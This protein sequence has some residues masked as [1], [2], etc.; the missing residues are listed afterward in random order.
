MKKD[1]TFQMR[2]S[3]ELEAIMKREAEIAGLNLSAYVEYCIR[4]TAREDQ[5]LRNM[6]SGLKEI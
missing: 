1:K 2:I 5:M 4:H 3:D 6:E